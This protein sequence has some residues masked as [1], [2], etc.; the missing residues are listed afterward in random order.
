MGNLTS[1]ELKGVLSMFLLL[2][3]AIAHA[4]GLWFTLLNGN[5]AFALVTAASLLLI[6]FLV[7]L[8]EHPDGMYALAIMVVFAGVASFGAYSIAERTYMPALEL[9]FSK[10]AV[11]NYDARS[12]I[13]GS[14]S[15]DRHCVAR[16]PSPAPDHYV[17]QFLIDQDGFRINYVHRRSFSWRYEY[18]FWES[19]AAR[20]PPCR[21]SV[22]SPDTGFSQSPILR[23]WQQIRGYFEGVGF[24]LIVILPIIGLLYSLL[25]YRLRRRSGKLNWHK[26]VKGPA[27]VICLVY[28]TLLVLAVVSA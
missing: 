26:E 3:V 5:L 9:V 17:D 21:P 15:E 1:L 6:A 28:V 25:V 19:L 14:I 18:Y 11:I 27:L 16:L 20:I 24:A 23:I 8:F 4:L 12:Q 7:R 2:I 13:D 10:Y 22:I